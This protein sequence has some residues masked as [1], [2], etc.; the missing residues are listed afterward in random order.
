MLKTK[1]V[2]TLGPASNSPEMIEKMIRAGMNVARLNFSHGTH[3]KHAEVI[4]RIKKAR[5]KLGVPLAIML[6]TKGPEIRL[7][8]FENGEAELKTGSTFTLYAADPDRVGNADGVSISYADLP[9]QIGPG[10]R[11]LL[12]DGALELVAREICPDEGLI[13]TEVLSGGVIKSGKG[14]NVPN[15]HLDMIHLSD[16]DKGDLIFGIEQDVDFVA[17]SFV[18]CKEDVIGTRKFLDYHGG[19]SIKIISKIENL[20]GVDNFSE[21]LARSDGIMVARGDMGVEVDFERLPGLQ[22]RFIKEC[23][24]SG[25]MVITATQMLESMIEKPT[26]T[27][28][29]ISD[30]ANAV[31]DGTSAVMLSGETAVG[32]YPLLAVRAMAKIAEQAEKDAVEADAYNDMKYVIDEDDVTAALCDAACTTA[33]DIRAKA[34]VTLTTTGKSARRMSKFRPIQPVV[35]ATPLEKTFHQ[36]A[37]SWGVYPVLSLRQ[38]TLE[39]LLVHAVD[40]AKELDLVSPGDLVVIAAGVPVLTPGNTN[41]LKVEVVKGNE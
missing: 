13:R 16:R 34:I 38:E 31:F 23:Y 22:K 19:H 2:C 25:K 33:R 24:Q 28:A 35:A 30:V 3:E 8:K 21:I 20:E 5:D 9:K 11:I 7:G 36:L 15:V 41:L 1:I 6:D 10:T 26:P 29:E 12:N 39:N 37:L 27:R 14:V 32:S 4:D 40:C 17:A 18:R